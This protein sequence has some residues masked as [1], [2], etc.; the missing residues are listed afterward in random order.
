MSAEALDD[1]IVSMYC[2]R[3]ASGPSKQ[4]HLFIS[5]LQQIP[6][7]P[8]DSSQIIDTVGIVIYNTALTGIHHPSLLLIK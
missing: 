5:V 7:L 4:H 1:H 6:K 3:I 8:N 2:K